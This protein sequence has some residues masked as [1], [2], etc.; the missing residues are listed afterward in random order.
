MQDDDCPPLES[1]T[2]DEELKD[3][4]L[5]FIQPG[6]VHVESDGIRTYVDQ[7]VDEKYLDDKTEFLRQNAKTKEIRELEKESGNLSKEDK[8]RKL[9]EYAGS[10][11]LK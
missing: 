3:N 4:Q 6:P 11:N 2:F 8:I 7:S 5:Q 9:A 1:V 10:S